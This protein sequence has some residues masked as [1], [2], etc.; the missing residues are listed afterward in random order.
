MEAFATCAK[1]WKW[2]LPKNIRTQSK[3]LQA[4]TLCEAQLCHPQD[5]LSAGHC[6]TFANAQ[7]HSFSKRIRRPQPTAEG[8]HQ[9]RDYKQQGSI[10]SDRSLQKEQ[11]ATGKRRKAWKKKQRAR[12]RCKMGPWCLGVSA[13][14][15]QKLA[16]SIL[17]LVCRRCRKQR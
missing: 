9:R 4:Q 11:D 14:A 7:V 13:L 8:A 16:G 2:F 17:E 10:E 3:A 12:K 15:F 5:T 6:L 1:V